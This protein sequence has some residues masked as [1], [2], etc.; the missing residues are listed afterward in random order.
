MF[1]EDQLF[2]VFEFEECGCDLEGFK[3]CETVLIFICTC[4]YVIDGEFACASYH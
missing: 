1:S 2:I 3:V 4:V